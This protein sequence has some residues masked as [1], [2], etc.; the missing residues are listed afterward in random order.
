MGSS[1]YNQDKMSTPEATEAFYKKLGFTVE[2]TGG[3]F[4][5]YQKKLGTE[6]IRVTVEAELPKDLN[7]EIEVG[8]YDQQEE[9]LDVAFLDNSHQLPR[10]LNER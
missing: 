6:I 7:S 1:R 10:F 2:D 3:G 5:C 8:V 4:F 9:P